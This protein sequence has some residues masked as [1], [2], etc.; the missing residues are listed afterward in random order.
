MDTYFVVEKMGEDYAKN[1]A[2]AEARREAHP[3]TYRMTACD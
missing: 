1:K 2:M 3:R